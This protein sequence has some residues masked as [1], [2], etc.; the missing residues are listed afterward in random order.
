MFNR[1]KNFLAGA[2][3]RET[4]V[5]KTDKQL[6]SFL[7]SHRGGPFQLLH[8]PLIFFFEFPDEAVSRRFV[9]DGVIFYLFHSIRKP[10]GRQGLRIK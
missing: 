8:E 1:E 4:V 10:E 5:L 9:D 7:K 3:H 6:T 2:L